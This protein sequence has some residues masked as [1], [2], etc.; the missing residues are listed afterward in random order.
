EVLNYD[1]AGIGEFNTN[2]PPQ[3]FVNWASAQNL[4]PANLDSQG[5]VK[6]AD[7]GIHFCLAT[8]DTLG[9][10]LPEPGID[11]INRVSRGWTNPASYLGATIFEYFVE[12]VI[13][14][15]TIWNTSKYMN[16]WIADMHDSLR[17]LGFANY[18]PLSGL[19]GV[20]AGTD[21][22]TNDGVFCRANT[23]G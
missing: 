14:P 21:T 5:R 18:P 15:Q 23:F 11:R 12:T 10:T 3:A 1:Y 17:L 19:A 8:K 13:K 6:I 7:C 20:P 4:P 9:N 2:Y 16:I 22:Y